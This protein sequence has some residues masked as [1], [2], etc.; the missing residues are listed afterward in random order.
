MRRQSH[1]RSGRRGRR[2]NII[3]LFAVLLPVLLGMTGLVVDCGYLM[4]SRRQLQNTADAAALAAAME[5]Y[6]GNANSTNLNAAATA[7][8]APN[9]LDHSSNIPTLV[10]NNPPSQGPYSTIATK[11][12]YVE[13]ILTYSVG[14]T[15]ISALNA[16]PGINI[17][18]TSQVQARAVAGY[19]RVSSGEGA[20]VLDPTACP[21]L[22]VTDNNSRL[23][24]NGTIVVNSQGSGY[25]Q[26][27][28]PVTTAYSKPAVATSNSPVPAPI[29]CKDLQVVGGVDALTTID[30]I[31]YY[32]PAFA[33]TGYYYDPNNQ[34]RPLFARGS[35][36][37]DPLQSIPTPSSSNGVVIGTGNIYW[38][39]NNNNSWTS[40]T[41][42]PQT[43]SIGNSDTVTLSPGI[44]QSISITGGTV[45]FT[46]GIYVIASNT[47]DSLKIN[48]G[49]LGVGPQ[50]GG[51]SGVMF[52]NTGKDYD[53][54]TGAPDSNDGSA[55]G[56]LTLG[57]LTINGAMGTLAPYTN[58]GNAN[59]PFNGIL[60]YQRRWNTTGAS[61]AGSS[62]LNMTGTIYAK[63]ADFTITGGGTYNAQ[64]VVGSLHIGGG[65][66]L[67]IN[68]T[69]KNWG[70]ANQVFLVE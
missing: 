13:V 44:Y 19:E 11:N 42:Y 43:V 68:A 35:I 48:G 5:L 34:D 30:N 56:T 27:G 14:T 23:I 49:T 26:Y 36:Q 12:Q 70:T 47:G 10:L 67:T 52:Y 8:F 18:Q 7:F 37:P 9:H 25:D 53:Y 55:R 59:D 66:I 24:V 2:G 31:R 63:W 39:Y 45:T 3:V 16:I 65:G 29:V 57:K 69:G 41:T 64:F 38:G 51:I 32:D 33:A 6:R 61:I 20:I 28:D 21:G 60:F 17:S 58:G 22:A 62:T 4:A 50:T 1:P 54:H 46:P 15:F 40:S